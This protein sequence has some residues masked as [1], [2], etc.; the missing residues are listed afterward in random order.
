MS[1]QVLDHEQ[2]MPATAIK[3]ATILQRSPAWPLAAAT[4]ACGGAA[5]AE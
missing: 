2:L 5:D 1:S 3:S 4:M